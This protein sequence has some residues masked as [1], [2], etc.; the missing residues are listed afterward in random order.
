VVDAQL[1]RLERRRRWWRGRITLGDHLDVPLAVPGGRSGPD[2]DALTMARSIATSY[3]GWQPALVEVLTEH[4]PEV[5]SDEPVAI[6]P[7]VYA[8]VIT[9]DGE[10]T[11]ELGYRVAWD[12]EHTLGARFRGGEPVELCG[13]VLEP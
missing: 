4:R 7:A 13:S 6:P 8:A 1:G 11:V 12:E 9:L 2:P 3:A 5:G 10:L